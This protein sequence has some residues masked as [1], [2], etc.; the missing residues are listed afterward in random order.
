MP[1]KNT[2]ENVW[3]RI[4]KKNPFD[5]WE[6]SGCRNKCGYGIMTY[7]GKAWL[8]HRWV[9][10]AING[11]LPESVMHTCD[12]PCCCNPYHLAAGNPNLNAKDRSAKGRNRGGEG[13]RNVG[14]KLTELQVREIRGLYNQGFNKYE[15]AKKYPVDH[16]AIYRICAR[17]TW[18]HIE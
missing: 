15:I 2:P 3:K 5:C 13:V 16:L 7:H 17:K 12:N 9:F 11:Y 14:S 8:V 18:R 6:W 10:R 1:I 4:P